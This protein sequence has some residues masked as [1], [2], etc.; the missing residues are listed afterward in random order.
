MNMMKRTVM[1]F[2]IA[3]M[4]GICFSGD[5]GS[6]EQL[7]EAVS[8]E[9][10][11]FFANGE[12]SPIEVAVK[13]I[14]ARSLPSY[15]L[16]ANE[17]CAVV[18]WQEEALEN[19]QQICQALNLEAVDEEAV[20][21][22]TDK[23]R[24][25]R[26]APEARNESLGALAQ[27]EKPGE[28]APIESVPSPSPLTE[29]TAEL[30]RLIEQL[31][32]DDWRE[33]SATA[34]SIGEMAPI[35]AEA[36]PALMQVLGRIKAGVEWN[37]KND[38][39]VAD[40]MRAL[41]RIGEP[42]VP[43]LKTAIETGR[44]PLADRARA[45]LESMGP[46]VG[47]ATALKGKTPLTCRIKVDRTEESVGGFVTATVQ[48][49]NTSTKPLRILSLE[50]NEELQ[51]AGLSV[52]AEAQG[53][54]NRFPEPIPGLHIK[55]YEYRQEDFLE[56]APGKTIERRIQVGWAW[57]VAVGISAKPGTYT[58]VGKYVMP[59]VAP[60]VWHGEVVSKPI[61]V[62]IKA[63]HAGGAA[64]AED[65]GKSTGCCRTDD[66]MQQQVEEPGG[67]TEEDTPGRPHSEPP[68]A[69]QNMNHLFRPVDPPTER[70]IAFAATLD[71]QVLARAKQFLV[72]HNWVIKKHF[73]TYDIVAARKVEQYILL[74]VRPVQGIKGG[75]WHLVYCT[76]TKD[77]VGYFCWY[78]QE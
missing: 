36:V 10:E 9:C 77:V 48:L 5:R 23:L 66:A 45:I 16:G 47:A 52:S 11:V 62:R 43:H 3:L 41:Q 49:T 28:A 24:Q 54:S 32:G 34:R 65:Q 73:N 56:L 25:T 31:Q 68:D 46:Q 37:M 44:Q 2:S 50:P 64:A 63:G 69:P 61:V 60:G 7:K 38:D 39:G 40:I 55:P 59:E 70:D 8:V 33:R 67:R 15:V 35:A 14:R 75:H 76:K 72:K 51:G 22:L 4:A 20:R 27:V 30:R 57:M 6:A 58:L 1:T 78:I 17:R 26:D 29:S 74:D 53:Y 21:R 71:P 12:H 18:V 19:R 13:S 42:A